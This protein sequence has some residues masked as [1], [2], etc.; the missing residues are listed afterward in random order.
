MAI[1]RRTDTDPD[2]GW[3]LIRAAVEDDRLTFD[4]MRVLLRMA[5]QFYGPGDAALDALD[6]ARARANGTWLNAMIKSRGTRSG[7]A[8]ARE[9]EVRDGPAQAVTK[10]TADAIL[11]AHAIAENRVVDLP[12][13]GSMARQIIEADRRRRNEPEPGGRL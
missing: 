12:A 1:D 9:V 2:H 13:E 7:R 5:L 4:D 10:A 8:T 3:S 6:A 11:K